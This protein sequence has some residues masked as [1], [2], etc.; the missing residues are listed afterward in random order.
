VQRRGPHRL[1]GQG[2][3]DLGEDHA[4]LASSANGNSARGSRRA[5][6]AASAWPWSGSAGSAGTRPRP[7]RRGAGS[8]GRSR[9]GRA[10][11]R[12]AGRWAPRRCPRAA[13]CGR[14]GRRRRPAP[15]HVGGGVRRTPTPRSACR[16]SPTGR[17]WS[18]RRRGSRRRRGG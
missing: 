14:S 18:G 1:P 10:G 7:G 9:A 15:G 3:E 4:S 12:P 8:R 6:S 17:A 16:T 13:G 11:C 2:R 5:A